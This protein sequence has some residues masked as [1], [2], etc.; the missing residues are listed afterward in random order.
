[1]TCPT[2]RTIPRSPV[3]GNAYLVS[4]WPPPPAVALP[5]GNAPRPFHTQER[6]HIVVQVQHEVLLP[7]YGGQ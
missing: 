4:I 2:R 1:M 5:S 6:N 7:A 3:V